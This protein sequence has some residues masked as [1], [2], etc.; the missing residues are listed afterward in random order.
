MSETER[1]IKISGAIREILEIFVSQEI[2]ENVEVDEDALAE[3]MDSYRCIADYFDANTKDK[4]Y[5]VFL[6]QVLA[7]YPVWQLLKLSDW[8]KNMLIRE[9][10]AELEEEKRKAQKTYACLRCKH[11]S[12]DDVSLGRIHKCHGNSKILKSDGFA[13]LFELRK[14]KCKDFEKRD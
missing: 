14:T 6:N 2:G 7:G 13:H 5:E 1:L 9:F 8:T 12:Y 4:M 11:Y 3:Y 10:N